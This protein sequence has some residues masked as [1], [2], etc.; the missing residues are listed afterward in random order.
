MSKLR[1]KINLNTN[2]Y[3]ETKQG[4]LNNLLIIKKNGNRITIFYHPFL[5]SNYILHIIYLFVNNISNKLFIMLLF[6]D[7]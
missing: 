4:D 2:K 6:K 1:I 3:I 7:I 5:K